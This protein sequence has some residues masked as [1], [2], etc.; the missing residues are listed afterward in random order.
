MMHIGQEQTDAD[1]L[2]GYLITMGIWDIA[3]D[4]KKAK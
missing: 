2:A 3:N 1:A 4:A